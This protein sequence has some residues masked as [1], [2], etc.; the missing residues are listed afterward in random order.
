MLL[1]HDSKSTIAPPWAG[2]WSSAS[3]SLASLNIPV[4]EL[5]LAEKE[6]FEYIIYMS[7]SVLA[8]NIECVS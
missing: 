7:M 4:I 8:F 2:V 6:F 5:C 1:S 3:S